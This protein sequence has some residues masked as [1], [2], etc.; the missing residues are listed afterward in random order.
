MLHSSKRA[1]TDFIQL[2]GETVSYFPTDFFY[3]EFLFTFNSMGHI[4]CI[5]NKWKKP[6]ERKI[7]Q[8]GKSSRK[9]QV[10]SARFYIF[11]GSG[12]ECDSASGILQAG[13]FAIYD[14]E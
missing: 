5:P 9:Y 14:G 3:I 1:D 7:L 13:K 2:C 4:Y 10:K 8:E 11:T 12:P 6:V